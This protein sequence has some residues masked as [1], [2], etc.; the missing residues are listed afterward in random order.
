MA[1]T[2]IKEMDSNALVVMGGTSYVDFINDCYQAGSQGYFD[3]IAV[4]PY[5]SPSN[6]DPDTPDNGN[7]HRLRHT[8]VLKTLM[9]SK[10]D[11][12]KKN[13]VY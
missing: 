11:S 5:M 3:V 8:P 2:G 10:G 6:L 7:I 12:G 13:M 1:Y 4:H 9:D